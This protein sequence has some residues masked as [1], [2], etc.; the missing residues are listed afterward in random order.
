MFLNETN[1]TAVSD[2]WIKVNTIHEA[3]FGHHIQFLRVNSD[4]LPETMRRGLKAD[5]LIEGTAHRSEHVCRSIFCG[6]PLISLFAYRR[7]HTSVRIQAD[8][9]LRWENRTIGEVVE[10]Y[11]RE[12]GF[13]AKTARG[14]VLAQE[15]MFG[16][17]TCCYC[18]LGAKIRQF[19]E[20]L[21]YPRMR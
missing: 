17:F 14:Q 9:M 15:E 6:R 20:S 12:L 4:P 13:D 16:Y 18:S 7:H 5:P 1:Y 3:Y 19:G 21:A 10:L 8:L 2:G 11:Q